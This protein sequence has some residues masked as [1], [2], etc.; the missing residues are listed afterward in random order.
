[1]EAGNSRGESA[2]STGLTIRLTGFDSF[3]RLTTVLRSQIL[4]IGH[5]MR[6]NKEGKMNKTRMVDLGKL[7]V[8]CAL[9]LFLNGCATFE[10]RMLP[11]VESYPD[12]TQTRLSANVD[13]DFEG[14]LNDA[15]FTM[16][17]EK[18]EK[19]L[20]D[21]C[22]AVMNKSNSFGVVGSGVSDADLQLNIKVVK[23]E[24]MDRA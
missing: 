24:K 7:L 4:R 15:P 5:D 21:K 19:H 9:L 13:L 1:M 16:Y 18:V 3:G 20:E 11:R 6:G 10:G 23:I 17:R 22:L 12:A 2:N 14:Y 8:L